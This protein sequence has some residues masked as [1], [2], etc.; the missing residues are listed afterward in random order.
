MSEANADD[1]RMV[2][3]LPTDPKNNLWNA[4]TRDERV[5]LVGELALLFQR[6]RYAVEMVGAKSSPVDKALTQVLDKHQEPWIANGAEGPA[7][8][9]VGLSPLRLMRAASEGCDAGVCRTGNAALA[10][11][12]GELGIANGNLRLVSGKKPGAKNG[13][14]RTFYIPCR[15][16]KRPTIPTQA[17]RDCSRY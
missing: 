17:G 2:L 6:G 3:R 5:S 8:G 16:E 12:M 9:Q 14:M 13:C 10:G 1:A 11:L 7:P 4:L 15:P